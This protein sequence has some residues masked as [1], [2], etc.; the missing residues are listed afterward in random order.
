MSAMGESAIMGFWIF[1]QSSFITER[2]YRK[3]GSFSMIAS[4]V[5]V[6]SFFF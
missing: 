1:D 2:G 4:S 6:Y 5:A 3:K